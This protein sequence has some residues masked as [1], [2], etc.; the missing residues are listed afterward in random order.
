MAPWRQ[1]RRGLRTLIRRSRTDAEIARE[2]EH[3]PRGGAE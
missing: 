3:F 1:F 2:V